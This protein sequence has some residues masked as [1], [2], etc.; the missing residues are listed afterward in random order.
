VAELSPQE[1]IAALEGL[2][3]NVSLPMDDR[4]AC[5]MQAI[6]GLRER[7]ADRIRE[8]VVSA[9]RYAY[10]SV[11]DKGRTLD[12]LCNDADWLER[13]KPTHAG[14]CPLCGWFS[15]CEQHCPLAHLRESLEA[16]AA[17]VPAP[18]AE[19]T[20][21]EMVARLAEELDVPVSALDAGAAPRLAGAAEEI[22]RFVERERTI[23]ERSLTRTLRSDLT[24]LGVPDPEGYEVRFDGE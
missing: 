13:W 21:A 1:Q 15:L 23:V 20:R 8:A 18:P 24:A 16:A 6:K 2:A 4:L 7:E 3:A 11:G 12:S 10:V 22:S 5:A 9:L 14:E 17:E 19:P